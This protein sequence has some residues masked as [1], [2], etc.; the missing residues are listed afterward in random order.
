MEL[1]FD[2][3]MTANDLY[4]YLLYHTYTSLS[5]ILSVIVGAFMVIAFAMGYSPIY[6]VAGIVVLGYLPY[7]FFIRS[8]KQFLNN[9]AFR[10]P[11][12]YLVNDEGITVSQGEMSE[13]VEWEAFVKAVSTPKSILLY[14]NKVNASI[15]SKRELKDKKMLFIQAIST[16]MDAKKVKI[17]GN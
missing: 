8:R 15:F 16:H 4:D 17:R 2:I 13:T 12:H 14:T 11:L 3:K 6:L 7:T 1:E 5:G 9:P 10:E